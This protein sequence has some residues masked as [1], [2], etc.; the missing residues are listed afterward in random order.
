MVMFGALFFFFF[1]SF[2][3]VAYL[4]CLATRRG[5]CLVEI[6]LCEETRTGMPVKEATKAIGMI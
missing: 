3:L 2:G 1:R 6:A 5:A 4:G